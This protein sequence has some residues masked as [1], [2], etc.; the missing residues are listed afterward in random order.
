MQH[1]QHQ[2]VL[3]TGAGS[4]L[5]RAMACQFADNGW[6]VG[7]TDTSLDRAQETFSGRSFPQGS[8]VCELDVTN[9]EHWQRVY[10]EVTDRWSGLG[11]LINNA[12]VAAAGPME[13][14]EIADWQWLFAINVF[15]VTQ[16]CRRFLPLLM[17]QNNGHIVNIASFAA[18]AGGPGISN[19]GASKAAVFS[20]SESLHTELAATDI[21]VSVV[22]PAFIS[23]DLTRTMRAPDDNY[24][25]RVRR[26]METSNYTSQ[27]LAKAVY[28][29][30]GKRRFILLTHGYTRWLWRL[31]RWC[32]KIYYWMLRRS[33]KQSGQGKK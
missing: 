10:A 22:C 4:G 31:K 12:G 28:Q 7:I 6:Q 1:I 27:D 3:I 16:G 5:G 18:L 2:T 14:G 8:F 24:Q 9:D 25:K 11:V 21:G 29:T 15:G 26:W 19:Y 17:Q 23:T 13:S 30:I 20:L 32:P 33:V